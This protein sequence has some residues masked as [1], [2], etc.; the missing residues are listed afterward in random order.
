MKLLR[1]TM[2]LALLAAVSASAQMLGE[3]TESFKAQ[4]PSTPVW[5]DGVAVVGSVRVDPVSRSVIV[6]GWVNQVEGAIELLACG[7]GGKTH[8][9]VFVLDV[10]A[11][12]LQTG[13]LLLGL[14]PG[15]PP[16][17]VGTGK[18]EG[19]ELDIWVD[20]EENGEQKSE[21]AERFV[22]NVETKRPLPKTP[23]VFT[24]SLFE[25]GQFRAAAEES[26]IVTYWDPWAIINLPLPCGSNDEIL[27][28]N[29][30]L[31][32]PIKVPVTMR[33]TTHK[34][35]GWFWPWKKK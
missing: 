14:K 20:W 22:F 31:V 10:N 32:P 33:I 6:S 19:P 8:E 23:W 26:Y 11:I 18:P 2:A 35:K 24:G 7:P 13:L 5:Q 4:V 30:K 34:D 28:V 3:E 29:R 16:A 9:T 1:H 17:G 21:R 12:D 27:A 15:K 25:E